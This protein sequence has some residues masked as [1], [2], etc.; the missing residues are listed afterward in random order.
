MDMKRHMLID[1]TLPIIK[2]KPKHAK[3]GEYKEQNERTH[4]QE[5]K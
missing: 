2:K 3:Q 1:E 5:D 4:V